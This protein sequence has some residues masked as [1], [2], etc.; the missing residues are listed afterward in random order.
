MPLAIQKNMGYLYLTTER[1]VVGFDSLLHGGYE[2]QLKARGFFYCHDALHYGRSGQGAARLAGAMSGLSTCSVPPTLLTGGVRVNHLNQEHGIM[3][4]SK[5]TPSF[6]PSP[7]QSQVKHL[8]IFVDKISPVKGGFVMH[9]TS[10]MCGF[11]VSIPGKKMPFKPGDALLLEYPKSSRMLFDPY[12]AIYH[13]HMKPKALPKVDNQKGENMNML[14][15]AETTIQVD[16]EGRFCLNDLHRA[17]GAENRHRPSLWL[18][19]RQAQDLIDE[20]SKA[21]IPAIQSKQGVGTYVCKELVYAYAMWISPA[22][23]LKVI[24][25]FDQMVSAPQYHVPQ[26]LPEALRLA[27]D[28]AD[29]KAEVE[30]KLAIAGPKADHLDRIAASDGSLNITDAAKTLQ[31]PPKMLFNHLSSIQWIYRRVGGSGWIAYQDKI[32]QKPLRRY[33]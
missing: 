6:T 12:T 4:K 29:Q 21:G 1:N 16:S 18:E 8:K 15:I 33:G 13:A 30:A 2:P 11:V 24:R 22:F 5:L 3:V 26:N 25:A 31:V 28:L 20:I 17:S 14:A 32:Q 10:G 27:A 7:D 23:N 9:V 19:N